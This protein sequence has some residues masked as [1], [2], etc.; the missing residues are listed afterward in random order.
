MAILNNEK[1]LLSNTRNVNNINRVRRAVD[2]ASA[3]ED[4]VSK[5]KEF[6][7]ERVYSIT[8]SL[9]DRVPRSKRKNFSSQELNG[10]VAENIKGKAEGMER[11]AMAAVVELV[12]SS[13]TLKL[14]DVMQHHVT[15][16][17]LS[18]F[19]AN[20]T[21]RKSQKSKLFAKIDDDCDSRT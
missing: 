11:D 17:C 19:N 15:P 8:K 14:E 18:I 20:G 12:D 21:F 9:N 1:Q 16:E 3:K 5:V 6:M 13:G 7:D 4:G 10:G 2:I